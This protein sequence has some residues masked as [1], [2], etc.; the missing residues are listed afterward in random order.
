ERVNIALES[1]IPRAMELEMD[2]PDL[3]ID[4]LVLT[5]SGCQQYVP[6]CVE[7]VR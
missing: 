4:P 5:V 7:A 3:L 6:E 1:L 2:L